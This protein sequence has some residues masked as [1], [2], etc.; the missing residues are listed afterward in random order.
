[1]AD[2]IKP[3]ERLYH[4]TVDGEE[5]TWF[6]DSPD[7]GDPACICSHCERPIDEPDIPLR[8]YK[9]KENLEARLCESCLDW[10]IR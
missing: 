2:T 10:L 1:M 3:S 5:L 7:V 8:L 9:E 6:E 4:L